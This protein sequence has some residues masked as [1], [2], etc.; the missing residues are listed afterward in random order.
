VKIGQE[1]AIATLGEEYAIYSSILPSP[2]GSLGDAHAAD[3]QG[4]PPDTYYAQIGTPLHCYRMDLLQNLKALQGSNLIVPTHWG[5]VDWPDGQQ[6]IALMLPKPAGQPLQ[7]ILSSNRRRVPEVD[8]ITQILPQLTS[9]LRGMAERSIFHGSIRPTTIYLDSK[10]TV[11]LCECVSSPPSMTQPRWGL[12]IERALADPLGRGVGT[13]A[14]DIFSLGMT[15]LHLA[16]ASIA[17]ADQPE[18]DQIRARIDK[19]T[20]GALVGR[21]PLTNGLADLLRGMLDDDPEQRWTLDVIDQ[22]SAG[23]RPVTTNSRAMLKPAKPLV[24]QG[25]EYW[26][27][28]SAAMALAENPS[29]ASRLVA[30]EELGKWARRTLQDVP[31][32]DRIADAINMPS[33]RG[34]A[35]A[36]EACLASRLIV[37]LHPGGPLRFKGLSMMP[38]AIGTMLQNAFAQGETPQVLAEIIAMQLPKFW[39]NSQV[40]FAGEHVGPMKSF[41]Q[42]RVTL[43]RQ[44]PGTGIERCFYDL[45]PG[46][47]LLVPEL[48]DRVIIDRQQFLEALERLSGSSDRPKLPIGRHAT[49]YFVARESDVGRL[50]NRFVNAANDIEKALGCL[51]VLAYF[52][53]KSTLAKLPGLAHW[54]ESVV[55]SCEEK[56]HNRETRQ[57][58]RAEL[59]KAATEGN[60]SHMYAIADNHAALHRDRE[61]FQHAWL[62][63]QKIDHNIHMLR[64]RLKPGARLHI[65]VG[66]EAGAA[67]S[68]VV[69]SVITVGIILVRSGWLR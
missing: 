11:S 16:V 12:T 4:Y 44:Q 38:Q 48:K 52:Q 15:I 58:V 30:S 18:K 63:Y 43:D 69:A 64:D 10:G 31:L 40:N 53:S 59:H 33:V 28:R 24:V 8:V 50:F 47:P 19:G 3:R 61:A 66:E 26:D 13:V 54:L 21:Q 60:L 32:A 49:A 25:E 36:T 46:S 27:P 35:G 34:K 5:V 6:R 51:Q 1:T 57:L 45:A 20:Y 37:A 9:T 42:A 65:T 41:E 55:Q 56:Y 62:D 29:E 23:R 7:A 39:F 2:E 14:D 17:N 68:G 67:V 22:W